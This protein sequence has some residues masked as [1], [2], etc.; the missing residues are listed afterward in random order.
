MSKEKGQK[1]KQRSTKHCTENKISSKVNPANTGGELIC[2]SGRISSPC[3][4]SE[5]RRVTLATK[6]AKIKKGNNHLSSQIIENK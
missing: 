2:S 4:T 1:D 6:P 5:T 3:S